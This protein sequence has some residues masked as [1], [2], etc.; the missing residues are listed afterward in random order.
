MLRRR[1]VKWLLRAFSAVTF[2]ALAAVA[3]AA[4]RAVAVSHRA[5][6]EAAQADLAALEDAH[7]LQNLLY[8]KGF[9]AEY[10]LTGDT[11]WLEELKRTTPSFE[12]WLARVTKEAT[13]EESA[14]A[15]AQLA[16]EYG[17]YDADRSRAVA[18]YQRGDHDEA[19][20]MLVDN[21]ARAARLRELANGLIKL[22]RDDVAARL[23]EGERVWQRATW[24]LF[25][26]VL[27]AMLGAAAVGYQLARQVGRPLYELVMRAE[28]AVGGARLEVSP[29][30]EIGDEISAV[31]QH[32][33]LLANRLT[34]AEKMSALGEMATAVAHEVLNPLTGVKTALQLLRRG[35]E[36]PDVVETVKAVD[37]EIRRVEG[38]ARRL[39]A[40]SRPLQPQ[41][42][43]C[44]LGDVFQR[45]VSAARPE[46]DRRGVVIEPAGSQL[47]LLADPE[48]LVQVLVNLTV[49]AC[50][51][52][53]SGG[54]VRLSTRHEAGW[55]VVDVR[56]EGEGLA[57]EI[58]ERLFTP[59]VTTKRDGHGL[60]LAISQNIA[61]A[62]GGRLEARANSPERGT[63]FSLWL[64]EASA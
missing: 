10:F 30:D 56:D 37:T 48:L 45:V 36:S 61:L 8:Q 50:Q 60:G 21:T 23:V 32:V 46:A 25:A 47:S 15:S 57:P 49:N 34:Q 16:A 24:G 43:P 3:L 52:M 33:T 9:V 13:T 29:Q 17:R 63:T 64:P 42:Q 20:R 31:A 55:W 4:V 12:E 62:H 19:T 2:A 54:R 58:V 26:A 51:A 53:P 7:E 38:L 11:R 6:T 5:A 39:V 44:E 14:R 35:N 18:T 40:F 22:R 27:I 1:R 59:F 28:S 41:K